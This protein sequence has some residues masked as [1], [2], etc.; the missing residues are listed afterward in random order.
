MNSKVIGT[1]LSMCLTSIARGDV[2]IEN[3]AF[4]ITNTAYPNREVMVDMVRQTMMSKLVETHVENACILWDS[5]RIYQ[6]STR[7]ANR[8]VMDGKLWVPAPDI[9]EED[10]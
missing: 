1:S 4:I 3:V 9:F 6:P 10:V 5:G 8:R 7:P 2:A